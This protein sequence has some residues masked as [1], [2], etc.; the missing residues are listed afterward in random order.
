MAQYL[1]GLLTAWATAQ[2]GLS[3]F[4]MLAYFWGRRELE[5]F[6]FSLLCLSLSLGSGGVAYDYSQDGIPARLL[7][8][9]IT[10]SGMILAAAFNLHFALCFA[11]TQ[12]GPR[13]V[14]WLYVV[15]LFYLV[16]LWTGAWWQHVEPRVLD[17]VFFGRELGTSSVS[18]TAARALRR[19][20]ARDG[21]RGVAG[22]R[23]PYRAGQ[24]EVG[25]AIH[26]HF[27]HFAGL[28]NDGASAFGAWKTP[29]R[30][31]PTPSCCMHSASPARCCSDTESE[32]TS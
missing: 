17:A 6:I 29:F 8:D 14:L 2:L 22:A 13:R 18:R 4:F 15:A 25:S 16:L 20:V 27:V 5:Y 23:V 32:K 21:R 30:S 10:H 28:A 24:R 3:V 11:K 26:R 7:A 1:S 31:C 19:G 9:Q 12:A